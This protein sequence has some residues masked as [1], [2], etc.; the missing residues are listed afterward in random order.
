MRS[1][2]K[3]WYI[4]AMLRD[5]TS[6]YSRGKLA[7]K[8]VSEML[9]P[10]W[11]VSEPKRRHSGDLWLVHRETG[12]VIRLEVKIARFSKST[13]GYSFCVQKADKHGKTSVHDADFVLCLCLTDG[14][15]IQGYLMPHSTI[16]AQKITIGGYFQRDYSGKYSPYAVQFSGDWMFS[17]AANHA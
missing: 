17:K 6:A 5:S 3:A 10:H 8:L 14:G 7:E 12:L 2:M 16:S 9:N 4:A 13:R 1:E 15:M 11:Y